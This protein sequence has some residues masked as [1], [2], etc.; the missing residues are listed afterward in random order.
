MDDSKKS[1]SNENLP[2]WF[3][4]FAE[5]QRIEDLDVQKLDPEVIRHIARALALN[6]EVVILQKGQPVKIR[7][8]GDEKKVKIEHLLNPK[9]SFAR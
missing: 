5:E 7:R 6:K 2:L 8:E 9:Y 4:L 1:S 3:K